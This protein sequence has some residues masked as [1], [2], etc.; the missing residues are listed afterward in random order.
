MGFTFVGLEA[1]ALGL[2]DSGMSLFPDKSKPGGGKIFGAESSAGAYEMGWPTGELNV[3]L[4][5]ASDAVT[6]GGAEDCHNGTLGKASCLPFPP[7][8]RSQAL[9]GN[10]K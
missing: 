8:A 5:H 6:P 7:L 4:K 10:I 1:K 2:A 9:I 3:C